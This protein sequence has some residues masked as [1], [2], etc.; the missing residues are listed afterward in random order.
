MLAPYLLIVS[1]LA[2]WSTWGLAVRVAGVPV[3]VIALYNALFALVFQGAGLLIAGR[4]HDLEFGKEP[5]LL[6]LLAGCGLANLLLYLYALEKATVAGAL[7]THYTAPVFVAVMAP[8]MLGDRAGRSML[9]ALGVSVAGL[10]MIFMPGAARGGDSLAGLAAG[11]ASGLMYAFVIMISR[12]VSADHHP[13]KVVF[14]QGAVSVAVL[15]PWA[16]ASGGLSITAGQAAL[17]AVLGL[18][19]STLA[20]TVYLYG[21]RGVTAQEAGILG[22]LEPVMGIALA[23]VFLGETP[24]PLA[25]IGGALILAAGSLVILGG[26]PQLAGGLNDNRG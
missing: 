13:L 5:G 7:L 3:H 10:M 19:H 2:V 16:A 14:I 6:V 11:T 18:L 12:R 26:S 20:L 15:A 17:F 24:Q 8:L 1:A 22:Y 9:V 25:V 23:F 4:K 21:I